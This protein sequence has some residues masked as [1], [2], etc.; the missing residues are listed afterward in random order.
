M[1]WRQIFKRRADVTW[2]GYVP[3][4]IVIGFFTLL[5]LHDG[6]V[7]VL[8]LIALFAICVL[9]LRYRTLAGWGLLFGLSVLYGVMVLVSGKQGN[10]GEYVFFAAC[11]FVP[12]AGLF[13]S[14][15]RN[16]PTE[17]HGVR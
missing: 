10:R 4:L 16:K 14:Y 13:L 5:G 17:S 6:I 12:A 8:P 1:I 7:G 9:Q 15:P 11:G 3:L 2:A